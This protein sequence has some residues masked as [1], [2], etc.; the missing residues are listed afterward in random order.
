MHLCISLWIFLVDEGVLL[1]TQNIFGASYSKGAFSCYLFMYKWERQGWISLMFLWSSWCLDLQTTCAV[2]CAGQPVRNISA[3]DLI[4]Y[5]HC[6]HVMV[7]ACGVALGVFFV[8]LCALFWG[9][10]RSFFILSTILLYSLVS[11]QEVSMWS[12]GEIWGMSCRRGPEGGCCAVLA[13]QRG[14][15]QHAHKHVSAF[16]EPHLCV[17]HPNTLSGQADQTRLPQDCLASLAIVTA[18]LD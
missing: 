7:L 10:Q 3:V 18:A 8:F 16:H 9:Q 13:F 12:V 1:G 17:D 6:Q 5:S 14:N 11:L 15:E 4:R 2:V